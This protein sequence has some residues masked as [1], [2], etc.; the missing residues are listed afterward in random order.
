MAQYLIEDIMQPEPVCAHSGQLL[1]DV[2]E[3]LTRYKN[4]G[5][6]VVDDRRRV[7]G[8][9]SEQDCIHSLL[10]TSYF[11]EGNPRVDE[12]MSHAPLCVGPRDSVID[13]ARTMGG[14]KPKVYPVVEDGVLI[15]LVTR[16]DVL[17]ALRK[18]AM[19]C[20]LPRKTG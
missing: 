1:I 4:T 11:C 6:P 10:A 5:I 16:N 13:L 15:G 17:K 12:V 9:I 20:S 8:F 18:E 14:N 2:V 3:I 7:V 19:N